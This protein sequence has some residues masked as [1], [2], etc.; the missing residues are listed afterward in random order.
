MLLPLQITFRNIPHSEALETRIR[1]K[2]AKLEQV[3]E[4]ITSC[5]IVLEAPHSHKHKGKIYA[6]HIDITVPEGEVVVSHTSND[7]HQHEDAYVAVRD[8]FNAARRQLES[9]NRK[10]RGEVKFHEEAPHGTVIELVPEEEYGRIRATDGREIYFHKNS[11][12]NEKFEK[13]AIGSDVRYVESSG[14]DGPQAS[15]VQLLNKQQL[16]S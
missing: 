12:V 1:E 4:R 9:F 11:I 2:V 7:K 16:A 15:T 10:Q 14:D 5:K 13:L 8:A 6:V 3:Y